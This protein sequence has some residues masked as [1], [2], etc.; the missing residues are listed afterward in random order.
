MYRLYKL[1]CTLYRSSLWVF[2]KLYNITFDAFANKAL[3]TIYLR[4]FNA[5]IIHIDVIFDIV[6]SRKNACW[7]GPFHMMASGACEFDN[8]ALTCETPNFHP[9][10]S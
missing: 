6:K 9:R 3:S 10:I 7:Y 8:I 4:Y 2:D 1:A 5:H